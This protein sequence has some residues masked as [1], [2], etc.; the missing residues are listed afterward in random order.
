MDIDIL[1]TYISLPFHLFSSLYPSHM[2]DLVEDLQMF[3]TI[4]TQIHSHVQP[5]TTTNLAQFTVIS[6][7]TTTLDS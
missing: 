7:W 1:Y 6:S 4:I 2:Y 5:S 3:P